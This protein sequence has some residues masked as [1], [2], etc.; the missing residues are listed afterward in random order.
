MFLSVCSKSDSIEPY[1]Q[2]NTHILPL[3]GNI[4]NAYVRM[5]RTVYFEKTIE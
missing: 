3:C 1:P 4:H 2:W 5:K